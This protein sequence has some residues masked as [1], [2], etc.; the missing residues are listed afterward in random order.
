MSTP[1]AGSTVGVSE[2]GSGDG[3][4]DDDEE[5]LEVVAASAGS[6]AASPEE[7]W[8]PAVRASTPTPRQDTIQ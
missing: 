2:V 3:V 5:E 6:S 4:G 8:H 7:D 1:S